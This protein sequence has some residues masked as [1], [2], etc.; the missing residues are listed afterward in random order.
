MCSIERQTFK[1]HA[2][3]PYC[4]DYKERLPTGKMEE[5]L[6]A[7]P[8]RRY[9]SIKEK[10]RIVLAIDGRVGLGQSRVSAALAEGIH[11]KTY[12]DWKKKTA[13][14]RDAMNQNATTLHKGKESCFASC[15]DELLDWFLQKRGQGLVI[16]CRTLM[17]RAGEI[18]QDFRRQTEWS[19]YKAI[20]CFNR[21]FNLV[22][23]ATAT[24]S[25]R[26]PS[27]VRE[28]AREYVE[29]VRQRMVGRNQDYILNMDQTPVFF[30]M[31]A[32]KTLA[33]KG[34]RTVIGRKA[35]DDTKR[36]SC[37]VTITASGSIL[38]TLMVFKG[39]QETT[40]SSRIKREFPSYPEGHKYATNPTAWTD[41]RI[42]LRWVNEILIP[43]IQGAPKGVVPLLL[44]D[45]VSLDGF[46][47]TSNY[48]R[49]DRDRK[50]PW[51]MYGSRPAS[52]RWY[53]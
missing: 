29:S 10:R 51:R 48:R 24:E 45:Q 28:E 36:V 30:N 25:A 50:H 5:A 52:R 32:K 13:Q 3:P 20:M 38:P 35:S 41:E 18:D 40:K 26:L 22:M 16:S 39:V 46:C 4:N 49:W 1:T 43:H 37:L 31:N 6:P 42:M 8:K 15:E 14:L 47:H 33:C 12:R 34:A 11:A 27:T 44:L 7:G 19:R 21:K 9:F 17:H 2:P 23:R 53:W